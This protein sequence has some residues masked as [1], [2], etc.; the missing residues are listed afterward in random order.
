MITPQEAESRV[1]SKTTFGGYNMAQVDDFLDTLIT[2]YTGLFKENA[3]LKSKLKILADKIEEY[4][5]TEDAVRKTLMTAQNMADTIV[6]EAEAKRNAALRET[7]VDTDKKITEIRQEIA[8]EE[9]RLSAARNSTTAF[10]SK[11][12]DLYAHELEYISHLSDLVGSTSSLGKTSSLSSTSSVQDTAQDIE[13]T[14]TWMFGSSEEKKTSPDTAP[15]AEPDHDE[16]EE[17][18]PDEE[19]AP[20]SV[21]Q[22]RPL[23]KQKKAQPKPEEAADQP[24]EGNLDDQKEYD[25]DMEFDN[26]Q[27][28]KDYDFE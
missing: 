17:S 7:R 1:F 4:R 15:I 11:L 13:N 23:G 5:S 28:G 10:V 18:I 14:M 9:L 26:L 22:R 25:E 3:A 21:K 20:T 8:N 27:F 2:D 19:P 6:R 12:K 24:E 16:M